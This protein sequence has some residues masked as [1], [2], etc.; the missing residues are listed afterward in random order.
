MIILSNIKISIYYLFMDLCIMEWH[1]SECIYFAVIK[2]KIIILLLIKC[3]LVINNDI[4]NN[5]RETVF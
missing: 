3:I 5:G 1:F 4:K 2:N